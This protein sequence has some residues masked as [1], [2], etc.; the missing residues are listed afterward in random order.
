MR[1][2]MGSVSGQSWNGDRA[3]L[4]DA[5]EL[6][7]R[8]CDR[9][10]RARDARFDGRF[11]IAVTS[12]GIYCRPICPARSP[13]DANVRYYATAAAAAAA[14]FRPCLR[15]RP[16]AAPGTPAWL[17]TSS[18]VSRA[19]R[20]IGEGALD[21]ESVGRL[22]DRLGVTSRH[23][24]RLF[25]RHLGATPIDVAQTRRMHFAKKLLDET[26][27]PMRAV[28]QAAGYGSVR[29]FNS[30]MQRI[31]K[32]TPSA[33]RRLARQ[34]PPGDPDCYRFQL[35]YRPPYDWGF[36]LNFLRARATPGVELVAD[37]VYR[38]S[39]RFDGQMGHLAVSHVPER[40]ALAIEVRCPDPRA[41][42]GIV[43]RVRRIFDLT[44]DPAVIADHLGGDRLLARPLAAH[45]G[46]RTP[47][48]WDGFEVAV[49]AILGQQVS[50]R[51][52]TT[53]AG[54]IA[55]MFGTALDGR[56]SVDRLFPTPAELATA[57]LERA[58]VMTSRATTIRT[59]ARR[60]V[61]GAVRFD[62]ADTEAA[63]LAALRSIP[64]VGDWTTQYIA[65]RAFNAPDAFLSG[66]LILRRAAGDLSARDLE[67][68]SEAW[69]PWRAYAVMLLWLDAS[70]SPPVSRSRHV[71]H[72]PLS[73]RVSR[74]DR[75]DRG[76]AAR[77]D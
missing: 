16:E 24:R 6:D 68:R 76:L 9:A 26:A 29:R 18:V 7:R 42:L 67:R 55:A 33:L 47:G 56:E 60:T 23:L 50:V 41:L 62:A 54:R 53:I 4:A 28:A 51:A 63:T 25:V 3:M 73:A 66:D 22:A 58:G 57:P 65:M 31:Y 36:V 11:F 75:L 12:T 15:C 52:A 72:P 77:V 40:S 37:G 71:P 39:I 64:G 20:L 69:R 19:L 59:L 1:S 35:A 30:E 43:E 34:Q 17:G 14:G 49:R 48:A 13:K 5:M 46:I 27:L 21:E 74:R 45:P 44:A 70:S 38:R 10:R 2:L 32:R 8:A 61:E